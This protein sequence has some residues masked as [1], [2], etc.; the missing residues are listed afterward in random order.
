MFLGEILSFL[1]LTKNG[2]QLSL[3]LEETYILYCLS[4]AVLQITPKFS[5]SRLTTFITSQ[6]LQVTSLGAV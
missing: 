1:F 6:F 5:V 2:G 4:F 3:F